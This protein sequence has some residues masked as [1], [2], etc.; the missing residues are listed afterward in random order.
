MF[1]EKNQCSCEDCSAWGYLC[2]GRRN[3]NERKDQADRSK[4]QGKGNGSKQ[5]AGR[6]VLLV[7][8]HVG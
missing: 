7:Y 4:P 5:S 2:R 6:P 3:E 1:P 8:K